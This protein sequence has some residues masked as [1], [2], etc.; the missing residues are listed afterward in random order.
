MTMTTE[1]LR[2]RVRE[3]AAS[4]DLPSEQPVI[5]NAGPGF[6]SFKHG[7]SCVICGDPD[8]LVAYFWTGG[9]VAHLH[10]A[11]DAVWKQEQP[12]AEA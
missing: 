1:Q 12:D 9:R 6:D 2:A 3:L 11:G 7:S 4:G 8:A 5:K 10:A